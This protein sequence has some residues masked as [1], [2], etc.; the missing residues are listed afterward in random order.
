MALD[1]IGLAGLLYLRT[2]LLMPAY[3]HHFTP[4]YPPLEGEEYKRLENRGL[5]NF[6][7]NSPHELRLRFLC[8]DA[9]Q[10]YDLLAC[11]R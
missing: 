5:I 1:D 10:G 3:E 4:L 6:H 9:T 7:T 11:R 8:L 2:S